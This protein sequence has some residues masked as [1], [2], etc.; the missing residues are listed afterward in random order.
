MVYEPSH[1]FST[2][3]NTAL[4][5]QFYIAFLW[6]ALFP[7]IYFT[8]NE[9]TATTAQ[10]SEKIKLKIGSKIIHLPLS[11][12]QIISTD[13]PYSAVFANNQKFLDYKTLKQFEAELNPTLFLRVHRSTIINVTCIKE[14]TSRSNGDYDA[15]LENGQVVRFSRHYRN[16]WSHLLQ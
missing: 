15:L 14:L 6:Y 2:M 9:L 12:V 7:I 5:N 1:R 4:S 11:A 10:Y 16:N 13:K 8:K 3:F